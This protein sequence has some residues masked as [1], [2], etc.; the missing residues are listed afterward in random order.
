MGNAG[1]AVKWGFWVSY[2][3]TINEI[4]IFDDDEDKAIGNGM[5]GRVM[6]VTYQGE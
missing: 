6:A 5:F 3:P 2:T 4:M 1:N